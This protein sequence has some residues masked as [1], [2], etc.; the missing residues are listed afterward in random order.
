MQRVC[1]SLLFVFVMFSEFVS[2]MRPRIATVK[3]LFPSVR[4]PEDFAS[5]F[6]QSNVDKALL[7]AKDGKTREEMVACQQAVQEGKNQLAQLQA[8]LTHEKE[9]ALQREELLKKA[10][11]RVVFITKER[12]GLKSILVNRRCIDYIYLFISFSPSLSVC[13]SLFLFLSRS[14]IFTF[15][16]LSLS[17]RLSLSALRY[18]TYEILCVFVGVVPINVFSV[19][20]LLQECL[21]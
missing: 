2:V 7:L 5:A 16:S 17:S 4:T 6:E 13:L 1:N 12:D 10:E 11:R 15:C 8:Q 14:H 20:F 21:R 18:V 3:Q 19:F 9:W